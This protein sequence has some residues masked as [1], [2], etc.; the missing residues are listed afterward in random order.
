MQVVVVAVFITL[1]YPLVLG[2]AEVVERVQK[3]LM[4]PE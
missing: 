2:V 3:H 4:S 1:V